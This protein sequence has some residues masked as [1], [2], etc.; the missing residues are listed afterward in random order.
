MNWLDIAIL[1]TISLF[2]L[3]G[4]IRGFIKGIFSI[5][6]IVG[7][8]IAGVMFNEPAGELFIKYGLVNNKPIASVAGFILIMFCAY[9]IIQLIGWLLTK[10]I[11]TLHLS[12]IDRIGGGVS[13]LITGVIVAFFL[14]S[15]LGF[16]FSEKVPPI[17]DSVLVP[18]V[19]ESF[20]VLKET[21]PEDFKDKLQK[22]REL[23]HEKGMKAA[24]EE[25]EKI[26]DAF[27]EEHKK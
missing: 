16:F 23:I 24:M 18:H 3:L 7:G 5:V 27:K 17:K 21:V 9:A 25:A 2:T 1:V 20:S 10:V 13:G 22:A 6:A 15:A 19:K 4:F 26:K 8:I 14:L 12:W 11:G